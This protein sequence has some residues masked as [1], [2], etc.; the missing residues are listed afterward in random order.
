ML[1]GQSVRSPAVAERVSGTFFQVLLGVWFY[2]VPAAAGSIVLLFLAAA[3][4]IVLLCIA[5]A[6]GIVLLFLAAADGIVL[7]SLAAAVSWYYFALQLL[8]VMDP[9]NYCKYS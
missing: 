1:R 2:F 9:V 8:V 6:T 7:L 4:G 3:G 5:V